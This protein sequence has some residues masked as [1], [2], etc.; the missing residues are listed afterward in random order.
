MESIDDILNSILGGGKKKDLVFETDSFKI[1]ETDDSGINVL[2]F[3]D[4]VPSDKDFPDYI[5]GRAN[6]NCKI[7]KILFEK[8]EEKGIKTYF[9]SE[10]NVTTLNVKSCDLL[11][12]EV[13]CKNS[14]FDDVEVESTISDDEKDKIIEIALK[15]NNILKSFLSTKYINATEMKFWFGKLGGEIVICGEMDADSIKMYDLYTDIPLGR[16]RFDDGRESV[17]QTYDDIAKKLLEDPM[18]FLSK[19]EREMF[20]LD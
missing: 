17:S 9:D 16:A 18:D 12:G 20:G 11:E 6:D 5:F 13:V 2:E 7:S 8:L 14:G 10:D 3:R 4:D 19:E 15:A 1:F